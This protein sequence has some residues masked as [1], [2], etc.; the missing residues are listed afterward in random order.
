MAGRS[1]RTGSGGSS[2]SSSRKVV[3]KIHKAAAKIPGMSMKVKPGKAADRYKDIYFPS[4]MDK[5]RKE[6]AKKGTAPK[7]PP[8]GGSKGKKK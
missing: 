2:S 6:W 8:I 3:K 5:R 4:T 1:P 7:L